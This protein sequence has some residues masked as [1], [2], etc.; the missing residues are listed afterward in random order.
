MLGANIPERGNIEL[1]SRDPAKALAKGVVRVDDIPMAGRV[2]HTNGT[3]GP[4]VV[5]LG[6]LDEGKCCEEKAKERAQHGVLL[7][8]HNCSTGRAFGSGSFVPSH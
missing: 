8:L 2:G 6:H 4:I 7:N 5:P 1:W 3:F